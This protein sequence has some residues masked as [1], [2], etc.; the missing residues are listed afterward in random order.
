MASIAFPEFAKLHTLST[1]HT[2]N[3]VY[4]AATASRATILFLHGFPSSCY[5][6]RHQI[7]HFIKQGYGVLAPDLLGYGGTSKPTGVE[8]YKLKSM[9][10]EIIELLDHEG[11]TRVH[12]VA[13]DTGCNLLSRLA[14]YYP[15]RLLSCTFIAVPYS[16]P[17]QHFD[18]DMVNK[19]TKQVLGF[20]K[21]GNIEYF[22]EDDAGS[23]MDQHADSFFTLFYPDSPDLWSQHLGPVGA[24][25][26]WL[27]NDKRGPLASYV[28]DEER[29][30]HN[31]I[32]QGHHQPAL[33]WYHGLVK[34]VNK[35][36]EV[37]ANLDAKL[38]MPVLM[39]GPQR[40][41]L[42]IP[43]FLEHMKDFAEEFTLKR[44]ST[45][46]HWIQLEAR[47]ELNDILEA[48]FAGPDSAGKV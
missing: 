2:Y 46:G 19:F 15:D 21:C 37:E 29:T 28:S 40:N 25:K 48:F 35:D 33:N 43:G 7:H 23:T 24:T 11:L 14:D 9:A 6:W 16:K 12:A 45:T 13:H 4:R 27:Q 1:S 20:E 39:I 34:N 22:V 5:D 44:V 10:K 41:K 31:K 42:E 38:K 36:D 26:A 3:Y 17:G 8:E 18:L 30:M 32:L 47:E